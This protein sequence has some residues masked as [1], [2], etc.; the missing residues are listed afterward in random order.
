MMSNDA[1]RQFTTGAIVNLMAIDCHRLRTVA[2]QLWALLSAPL[3]VKYAWNHCL[4]LFLAESKKTL[5]SN[6]NELAQN[7]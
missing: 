1:R 5:A 3:Q 7:S 4:T 6:D 2:S